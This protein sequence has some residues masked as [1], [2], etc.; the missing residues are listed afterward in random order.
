MEN[1]LRMADHSTYLLETIQTTIQKFL[2][3]TLQIFTCTNEV[4]LDRDD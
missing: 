3:E 4:S 2:N 1:S